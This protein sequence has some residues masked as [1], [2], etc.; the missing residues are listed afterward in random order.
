MHLKGFAS[1]PD[2]VRFIENPDDLVA[3]YAQ[4]DLFVFPSQTDTQGIVLAESLSQGTPIIA[5]EGYGQR[6]A[7]IE[8][9]NGFI[10]QNQAAMIATIERIASD[11]LLHAAL[12]VGA[13]ESSLR[14]A[15]S[16]VT[17]RLINFYRTTLEN[18]CAS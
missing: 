14:Y 15:P 13:Q 8:G 2:A 10:V 17:D 6:D 1:Y 4:S 7:I 16:I 11:Q 3:L 5:L 9:H 18:T 12:C